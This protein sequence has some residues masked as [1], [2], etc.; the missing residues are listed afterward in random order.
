MAKDGEPAAGKWGDENCDLPPW[1]FDA[2]AEFIGTEIQ[3][4]MVLWTGDNADHNIWA[5]SFDGN[6]M[7]NLDITD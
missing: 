2:I 6:M 7:N 5:Q 4:D 1:T 3:P